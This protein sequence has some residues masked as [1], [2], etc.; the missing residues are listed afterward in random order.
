MKLTGTDRRTGGQDPILSQTD[1]LT[2]KST[3]RGRI[4]IILFWNVSY[5]Y[6]QSVEGPYEGQ[7][8]ATLSF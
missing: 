8:E 2:K 4:D 1:A 3:L 7:A 5:R 6:N